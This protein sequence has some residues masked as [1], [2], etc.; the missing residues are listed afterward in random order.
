M[1]IEGYER[2]VA[3]GPILW[4]STKKQAP[5][6]QS[7]RLMDPLL[8]SVAVLL[9]VSG[10][11][12]ARASARLGF[13]VPVLSLTELL[14]AVVAAALAVSGAV[15]SGAGPWVAVAGVALLV[16]SSVRHARAVRQQRRWREAS[17]ARRLET[18]LQMARP[19]DE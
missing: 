16:V 1:E 13:G 17:E 6:R 15:G 10:A 7:K 4:P 14:M 9:A 3:G 18:Y 11:V 5:H 12:K 2:V 19:G 8:F